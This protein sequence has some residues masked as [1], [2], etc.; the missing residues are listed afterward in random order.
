[1]ELYRNHR[2]AR[3]RRVGP[4]HVEQPPCRTSD[5]I[6]FHPDICSKTQNSSVWL[7][8]PLRSLS[9]WRYIKF[10]YSFIHSFNQ[11]CRE[12]EIQCI[13]YSLY[14]SAAVTEWPVLC[15]CAVKK[16]PTHCRACAPQACTSA[17]DTEFMFTFYSAGQI[18][19][20]CIVAFF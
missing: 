19:R 11:F 16:L 14:T 18:S 1:M 8:A 2:Q 10:T 9:N 5:F 12:S 17:D 6:I 7:R 4:G 13:L 20:T 15:R 3:L